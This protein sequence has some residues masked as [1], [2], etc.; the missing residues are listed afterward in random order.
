[1]CHVSFPRKA[2]CS[3]PRESMKTFPYRRGGLASLHTGWQG[4]V[5]ACAPSTTQRQTLLQTLPG[6]P[7]QGWGAAHRV[8]VRAATS[9]SQGQSLLYFH[10]QSLLWQG[11]PQRR[12]HLSHPTPRALHK[13]FAHKQKEA[14]KL[15]EHQTHMSGWRAFGNVGVSEGGGL[16]LGSAWRPAP[17]A[18]FLSGVPGAGPTQARAADGGGP[19]PAVPAPRRAPP[20]RCFPRVCECS[21]P[22]GLQGHKQA[23][24][25]LA[26]PQGQ[27]SQKLRVAP[28]QGVSSAAGAAP[29]GL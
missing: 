15:L 7:L 8:V 22:A 12:G 23:V 20:P 26:A 19:C 9:Y 13:C 29:G 21:F 17:I 25:G 27:G 11:G 16:V 1:M 18:P 28:V 10:L 2:S 4:S 14:P 3:H 24:P 6:A 5:H